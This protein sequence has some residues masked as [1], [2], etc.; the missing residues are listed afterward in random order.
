MNLVTYGCCNDSH[1]WKR[2]ILEGIGR[3]KKNN[4]TWYKNLL[5]LR[6]KAL[7]NIIFKGVPKEDATLESVL[8]CMKRK[9]IDRNNINN[10]I[11]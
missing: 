11:L 10:Q 2:K 8:T 9:G 7:K 1:Y 6:I 4:M 3:L 5:S